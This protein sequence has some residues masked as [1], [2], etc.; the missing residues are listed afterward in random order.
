MKNP[1]ASL[2]AALIAC[3]C[4]V[5]PAG[6]SGTEATQ[7]G[8]VLTLR[9]AVRLAL[10]HAPELSIAEIQAIR[11]GEALREIRSLDQ[12]QVVA[13]SGLAYNNGFPL[14]IEGAAPSIVQVGL[15]KSLFNRRNSRLALE[16]EERIKASRMEP[17]K[18][19]NDLAAQA[20]LLYQA[21]FQAHGSIRI[22]TGQLDSA[23]EKSAVARARLE[24][25]RVRPLDVTLAEAASSTA[26]QQLL[27]A[28]EKS[29]LAE[30]ELKGMTGLPVSRILT[31]EAPELD[32]EFLALPSETLYSIALEAHP[33]IL[34]AEANFLALQFHVE[35]NMAEKYPKVDVVG[36]YALF[37]R[38]NNYQD[39]FNRFSRNNF[40]IGLS[41]QVPI[42]TGDRINS[43]VAR[44]RHEAEAARLHLE[45]LRLDLKLGIES[46][47]SKLRVAR[48]AA[49]HA[50]RAVAAAE[51]ELKVNQA[52]AEA[53]R[54]SWGDLPEIS[55]RILAR[56]LELAESERIIFQRKVELLHRTGN[57]VSL[58]Q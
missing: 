13:G 25:G 10:R 14:S 56:R 20:A 8:Q 48:G 45:R 7:V 28:R 12:P 47:V 22:W 41:I 34:Q 32:S 30:I 18:T 35:A 39:Y 53:G 16:A 3:S 4:L 6:N 40:L 29:R 21:L 42:F 43:R 58:F 31:V 24:A 17:D 1:L 36:Q 11:A 27:V 15:S 37:S 51:E 44:S 33:G 26:E 2:I 57:L 38:A 23:T 9:Q 49:R 55:S 5:F 19:R 50:E 52:L 54:V 46:S